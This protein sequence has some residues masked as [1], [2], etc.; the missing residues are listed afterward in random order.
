VKIAR[1]GEREVE[2]RSDE[3]PEEERCDWVVLAANWSLDSPGV[4]SDGHSEDCWVAVRSVLPACSHSDLLRST[5][6][7]GQRDGRVVVE[8]YSLRVAD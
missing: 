8:D 2:F 6:E 3:L 1:L 5:Q 7:A 4:P